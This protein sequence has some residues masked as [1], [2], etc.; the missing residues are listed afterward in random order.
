[1]S[2]LQK[3]DLEKVI[4]E[5]FKYME[6]MGMKL[7]DEAKKGIMNELTEKLDD[8]LSKDDVKDINVQ[9]KLLACISAIIMNDKKS[10]DSMLNVLQSNKKD[11]PDKNL[12]LKL[13]GL[14]VVMMAFLENK[15][16]PKHE[17][18]LKTLLALLK[19]NPDNK[20]AKEKP[21]DQMEKELE[22]SLRSLY[23]G[24]DPRVNGEV[25][26]P[27]LIAV[28]NAFGHTN[29]CAADPTSCAEMVEDITYNAGRADPLGLENVAKQS[30][31][32][33]GID[34]EGALYTSPRP[35]PNGM[36]SH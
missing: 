1:M 23:G 25:P 12:D 28:S 7:N 16:D 21:E 15:N 36:R 5:L 8:Q 6:K 34:M 29:Q 27:V 30:E 32:S 31:M 20:K 2:N 18:G 24:N 9:K 3:D 26:F 17:A 10:L 33:D 13:K 22:A 11:D 4:T 19:P 35:S 14:F